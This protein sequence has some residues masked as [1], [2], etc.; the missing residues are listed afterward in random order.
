MARHRLFGRSPGT[1]PSK[2]VT[3]REGTTLFTF[4]TFNGFLVGSL[5]ETLKVN[6]TGCFPIRKGSKEE[7]FSEVKNA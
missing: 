1:L 2:T 7:T 5:G 3:D 4:R 6:T